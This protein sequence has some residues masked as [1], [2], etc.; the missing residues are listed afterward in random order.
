MSNQPQQKQVPTWCS[1]K[2]KSEIF[3]ASHSLH[4][5]GITQPQGGH[6]SHGI[7]LQL[8]LALD[9]VECLSETI[10]PAAQKVESNVK[11]ALRI[12][13]GDGIKKQANDLLSGTEVLTMG[14]ATAA[15]AAASESDH[16]PKRAAETNLPKNL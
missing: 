2:Q 6:L 7:E 9:V 1:L 4:L 12:M 10:T 3:L 14:M 11:N 16:N 15:A 5:Q 8:P 13:I